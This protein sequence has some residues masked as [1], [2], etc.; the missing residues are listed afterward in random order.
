MTPAAR[1]LV[2]LSGLLACCSALT[3]F[4][5][6][7]LSEDTFERCRDI[8]DNDGDGLA[9]CDDPG[10]APFN[11]CRE[12]T[13]GSCVDG[14]D[15]DGDGLVDC[16]DPGCAALP[17]VCSEK[18]LQACT[19]GR[20]NDNDGHVDC[21]DSDCRTLEVCQ[22]RTAADCADG[23]DNDNDGLVDCNDFDCYGQQVCCT[24]PVTPFAGDDFSGS[25]GCSIHT[26][27]E[28]EPTCCVE[29]Y[30]SCNPF[31]AER[32]VAWGLPRAIQAG[33][34]FVSNEPCGC[35][36]SGIVSVERVS[37]VG[38][39]LEATLSLV[40]NAS[41]VCVG[42]T[43][44]TTF[45]DD[46]KQCAGA[47]QPRLL[48]GACLRS[49]SDASPTVE[50]VVDGMVQR[51]ASVPASQVAVTI[52]TDADKVRILAGPLAYAAPPLDSAIETALVLVHGQGVGG[53]LEALKVTSQESAA[54]RC[55]SP[56][57]WYRHLAR[58]EP[59]IHA[60][61]DLAAA[62]EP[63]VVYRPESKSY[64]MLFAGRA[65]GKSGRSGLFLATST[66][67]VEWKV[68]PEPVIPPTADDT[69]FGV[70][71][72]SPS[73][74]LRGGRLHL[75]Y[76]REDDTGSLV[77]R[78]IAHATSSGGVTWKPSAG[79]AGQPYVLAPGKALAWD[80]LAV[81]S[82]SV[83]EAADGSL[84][85]WYTGTGAEAASLPAI[86]IASSKD[87]TVWQ[88]PHPQP[89]LVPSEESSEL[90]CMDPSVVYDP[91][92]KLFLMWY[93]R[94]AFGD[95][96]SIRFAVSADGVSWTRWP[97]PVYSA[98]STGTFDERGIEAPALLR[99]GTRLR[100]WYTGLDDK[101][102]PQIGYAENRG[103]L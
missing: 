87:G 6:A 51:K 85:M 35:E 73:L 100:L 38:A 50:A 101:A 26:C 15:N 45:A 96:P 32:W 40:D 58:G 70:K 10:C 39:K 52:E 14:Q 11:V 22:E 61:G 99:S 75:W 55:R 12:L 44:S 65:A 13:P 37:V 80:S 82:P 97:G 34:A 60:G 66:D 59:V 21:N 30:Q 68:T 46:H 43:L 74:L 83:V 41:A 72:S 63:A 33:G 8:R 1:P 79:G 42:F 47:P 102:I 89:V 71:Q 9:D 62:E 7:K 25:S 16:N 57:T 76:T 84:V 3:T 64:V 27:S 86:G 36:P 48:L 17:G 53:R 78:T 28:T 2:A 98:G 91:G 90:A 92:S 54:T 29:G 81:S 56:A 67:G 93:T 31:D 69:R 23:K 24:I 103:G 5:E 77:Q 19:D 88:R 95:D 4:D 49:T 18:T 20:D 94:R